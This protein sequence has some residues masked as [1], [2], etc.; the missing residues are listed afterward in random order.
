MSFPGR[1][2]LWLGL[3][4]LCLPCAR[5]QFR[6]PDSMKTGGFAVGTLAR[7]FG[8]VPVSVALDGSRRVEAPFMQLQFGQPLTTN[9][10]SLVLNESLEE[11]EVFELKRRFAATGVRPLVAR[12]NFVA[13]FTGNTRIFEVAEKL[14]V[15]VLVA[16]PPTERLD[17]IEKLARRYIIRVGLLTSAPDATGTRPKYWE[18]DFLLGQLRNRSTLLGVVADVRNLLRAGVEPAAALTK[19]KDRLIG[20]NLTGLQRADG[21]GAQLPLGQGQFDA[22]GVLKTLDALGFQ[23]FVTL[24][25]DPGREQLESDLRQS[26]GFI[27]AEGGAILRDNM[28]RAASRSLTPATGL[29]YEV[30]VQGD[31]P[32]PVG[33]RVAADGEVWVAGRRGHVWSYRDATRTN[34][35]AGLL[36]VQV[37]GQRGLRG[38]ELDPAFTANGH[39]YLYY[40]PMT[41]VGTS[42]RLSRFTVSGPPGARKL[43]LRSERILLEIPAGR[44][45]DNDG[46]GLLY[47]PLEHV[48]YLGTGD[49]ISTSETRKIFDDPKTPAQNL[50]DPRGKILRVAPD[51]T[52]P[53][54]PFAA[55]SFPAAVAYGFR[56]PA[57]LSHDP[58]TGAVYAGDVGFERRYDLEEINLL[59]PGGNYG[60]PRCV[61][62]NANGVA[63][64]VNTISL[65][66]CPLPEA[67]PPWFFYP[68]DSAAAVIVGPVLRP[69]TART[70]YPPA[71]RHG[72][73][74]ADFARKWI[75]FAQMDASAGVVTNTIT[76]A[77]GLAGGTISLTLGPAGELYFTEYAGWLSGSPRDRLSRLVVNPPP[78]NR[79]AAAAR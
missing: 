41:P 62:T 9:A 68:H 18:P 30:L 5:A 70:N 39:L 22:R 10:N 24:A 58:V 33:V 50:A 76:L 13:N 34:E 40:T 75:R 49:G 23:G 37:A 20:V 31:L 53:P 69:E 36:N 6:L 59:R 77:G 65:A 35:L 67:V 52:V 79:V 19:F 73:V 27:R 21:T 51:G 54:G 7:S 66:E 2:A 16:E 29:R 14:G 72:M 48:L 71:L 26:L 55:D 74:Y 12:V 56:N 61:S 25:F 28:L 46:G 43:D 17:D 3:A 64:N 57:S 4:V 47:H 15:Q 44:S 42:N 1:L 11:D 60:W 63:V 38:L 78:T 8:D 32:E 45:G